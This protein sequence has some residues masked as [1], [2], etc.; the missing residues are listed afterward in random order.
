MRS[1]ASFSIYPSALPQAPDR[2]PQFPV[3]SPEDGTCEQHILSHPERFREFFPGPALSAQ[4]GG[5]GQ[6]ATLKPDF[7]VR[8]RSQVTQGRHFT[9][10]K[11]GGFP[12][13]KKSRKALSPSPL[14]RHGKYNEEIGQGTIGEPRLFPIEH[15]GSSLFHGPRA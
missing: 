4:D 1:F 5:F 12:R 7:A 9:N 8:G 3:H 14:T 11:P 15:I 2:L 6:V 10:G 13:D